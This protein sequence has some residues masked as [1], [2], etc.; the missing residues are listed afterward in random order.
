VCRRKVGGGEVIGGEAVSAGG[1]VWRG[2]V[3]AELAVM[4]GRRALLER[5]RRLWAQPQVRLVTVTGAAGMG[6]TRLALR[7]ATGVARA[8]PDGVWWVDLAGVTDAAR[9]AEAVLGVL[10][11]GGQSAGP[12]VDVVVGALSDRRA[13]VVLDNCEG[14]G[15]AVGSLVTRLLRGCAGLRV[16]ATSRERLRVEGEHLLEV[17]GLSLPDPRRPTVGGSEAL[18]LFA[19]L[20]EAA[21][22]GFA[23]SEHLAEVARLVRLLD[24]CPLELEL[25]A[26]LVREMTVVDILA[27]LRRDRFGVL[28]GGP[29]EPAHHRSLWDTIDVSYERCSAE[30][31]RAWR[32]LAVVAGS[33]TAPAA[34]AVAAGEG[35]DAGAVPAVLRGLTAQHVLHVDTESTALTRYRMRGAVR[36]YGLARLRWGGRRPSP[37]RPGPTPDA[38]DAADSSD[39]AGVGSAEAA[40]VW[41]RYTRY[42]CQRARRCGRYWFGPEEMRQLG[43]AR[44]DLPTYRDLL[45]RLV[46]GDAGDVEHAAVIGV[47]LTAARV[48]FFGGSV[49]EASRVLRRVDAALAR[50]GGAPTTRT[51]VLAL[52]MWLAVCQGDAAAADA[53]LARCREVAGQA[54]A[55][56]PADGHTTDAGGGGGRDGGHPSARAMVSFA[57]ATHSVYVRGRVDEGEALLGPIRDEIAAALPGLVPTLDL[58]RAVACAFA[59]R[60]SQARALAD[61]ILREALDRGADRATAWARW[62]LAWVEMRFGAPETARALFRAALRTHGDGQDRWGAMWAVEGLAWTAAAGGDDLGAA[63]LWGAADTLRHDLG[64]I[65]E[66]LTLWARG[67]AQRTNAV[68]AVL[69]EQ[70]WDQAYRA[71]AALAGDAILALACGDPPPA[72][73]TSATPES[74]RGDRAPHPPRQPRSGLTPR[75]EHVA[76]LVAEG[77]ADPEIAAAL[78]ISRR[79]VEHHVAAILDRLG[80]DNRTQLAVWWT[81][82]AS[83]M[84]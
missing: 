45:D 63:R 4:V 70:A 46:E 81:H 24:G 18:R 12:P 7:L 29:A 83:R 84:S 75:Q 56:S 52:A 65:M 39:A 48:W 54:V 40:A 44:E 5:A 61:T 57:E 60:E 41:A 32:R 62:A 34:V 43:E 38:A 1:G 19:V 37:A 9:V 58:C 17:G 27:E 6:K 28:V 8:V 68:R 59:A 72:T 21:H 50:T 51:V 20:A 31:Q 76:R 53:L 22:P 47:G 64:V 71:G 78:V 10:P 67:H 2:W 66:G 42:F 79:T 23:M 77:L 14:A 25:A 3:P 55:A 11:V 13:V 35:L 80:V 33:F 15:A 73:S 36:E 26:P 82:Y 69:G 16:I 49:G 30:E 74:A